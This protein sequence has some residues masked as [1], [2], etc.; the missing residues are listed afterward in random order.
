M[1]RAPE[2]SPMLDQVGDVVLADLTPA[3]V[4]HLQR[5][6]TYVH[7]LYS[8]WGW[9]GFYVPLHLAKTDTPDDLEFKIEVPPGIEYFEIMAVVSYG[10]SKGAA[11]VATLTSTATGD[12]VT[13]EWSA[14]GAGDSLPGSFEVGAADLLQCR[15]GVSWQRSTDTITVVFDQGSGTL[16]G[17][18]FLPVYVPA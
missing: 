2:A 12:S 17:L 9:P 15:S 6:D 13:I 1:S 16:W 4:R 8:E 18:C 14:G 7:A 5:A 3:R 10:T 11:S